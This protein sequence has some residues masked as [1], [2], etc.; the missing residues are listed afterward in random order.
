VLTVIA[1]YSV[2]RLYT[3]RPWLFTILFFVLEIDILMQARRSGKIRELLWLPIIF[4]LWANLH[5][6]FIDG[7]LVLAI[8]LAEAVLTQRWNAIRTRLR[9]GWM[10]GIFLACI[11]ATLVNPYGWNIYKIAYTLGTQ[12]GV[13]SYVVESQALPFRSLSDWSVL[14][15]QEIVVLLSLNA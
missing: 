13:L 12:A 2:S 15:R 6:Q 4:G 8:A 5:I 14:L 3:P 10:C 7:L 11:L 1:S 9:A